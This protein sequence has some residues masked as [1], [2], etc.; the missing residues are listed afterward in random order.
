MTIFCEELF[1][2]PKPKPSMKR[3]RNEQIAY[4]AGS[5]MKS[6]RPNTIIAN[7]SH[8]QPIISTSFGPILLSKLANKGEKIAI[9]TEYA[10]KTMPCTDEGTPFF[11]A[12]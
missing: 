4:V 3:Q 7:P 5:I 9:E 12:S 2:Q 10:E 1:R 11:V 6:N 8:K